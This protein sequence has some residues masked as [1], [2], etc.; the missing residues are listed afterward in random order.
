MDSSSIT[1]PTYRVAV[2]L[3]PGADAV[4]FTGPIEVLSVATH[5]RAVD[6]SQPVFA[7]ETVARAKDV[8]ISTGRG[9]LKIQPSMYF[10]ELLETLAD[11]HVLVVPGGP[12]TTMEGVMKMDD[13]LELEAIKVFA[14][15]PPPAEGPEHIILSVCTGA[16]LLGAAGVLG[17][18]KV[19]T[20]HLGLDRLKAICDGNGDG[21]KTEVVGGVRFVDAGIVKEGLRIVTAGGIT[22]GFDASLHVVELFKDQD[23]ADFIARV[24]EYERRQV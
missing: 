12:I 14:K 13:G 10:A 11:F 1:K 9:H 18:L 15:L 24:I 22:S 3:F 6:V 17:G 2:L 7:I 5:D 20:H 19:T 4:D 23:T 21:S 16:F 8:P